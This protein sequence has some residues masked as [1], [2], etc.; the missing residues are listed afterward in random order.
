MS[1]PRLI[2]AEEFFADPVFAGASLSPDGTKLA[3]LAPAHGRLNVW[4][5]GVG[6]EH[7][8]AVCVTHDARRGIKTYHWTDDPRWLLYLQDTDGNEDW[9]LLRVDLENP[10]AP[11]VDLTPLPIG[12][13]VLEVKRIRS[14]PGSV[15]VTMNRRPRFIDAFR[16]EIATGE[17]VLHRETPSMT[18]SYLFGPAGEVFSTGLADDGTWEFFAV[19]DEIGQERLIYR[20]GGPEHPLRVHPA[21]VTADG[22]GLL[23][24]VYL[25][26][27]D[28]LSLI[29]VDGESGEATVVAAL[30]GTVCAP[31]PSALRRCSRAGLRVRCWRSASSA[32]ARSSMWSTRI[33][34]RCTPRCRSSPTACW[35]R[36]PPTR[37]S[38]GGSRRSS[39]TPSR[40][41]STSTTA[42][43]AR[44]GCL[45]SRI[46]SSPQASSRPRER[47]TSRPATVCRCT[48]S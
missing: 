39:M 14:W 10:Q 41:S 45:V 18:S 42:P 8:D 15:L 44:A 34:P 35:R 5:R 20:C 23:L 13:G 38:S 22:K 36:C 29:R 30:P 47:S 17:T 6:E 26:D 16:I 9:H 48:R 31:P 1:V 2:D 24:G 7:E 32:T 4:V 28:D 3:Y 25:G 37:R 46:R 27:S 21:E 33:S 12:S 11:A 40:T 19:D 43:R